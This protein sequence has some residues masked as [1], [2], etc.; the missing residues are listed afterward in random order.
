MMCLD[1]YS[2][3]KQRERVTRFGDEV[4]DRTPT[5]NSVFRSWLMLA[6]ARNAFLT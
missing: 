1:E 4:V 6:D 5:S 3:N 2:Q